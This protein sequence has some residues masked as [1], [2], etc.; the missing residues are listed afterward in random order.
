[1][2]CPYCG[3]EVTIRGIQWECGFCGDF[4]VLSKQQFLALHKANEEPDE[5]TITFSLT[6]DLDLSETWNEM[7]NTLQ[8]AIDEPS[9]P[10]VSKLGAVVIYEICHALAD[11]QRRL[12]DEKKEKLESFLKYTPD[13]GPVPSVSTLLTASSLPISQ[14]EVSPYQTIGKLTE[15]VCGTFWANLIEYLP[16]ENDLVLIDDLFLFLGQ[17]YLYFASDECDS[18]DYDRKNELRDAFEHHWYCHRY[19]FP[20]IDAAMGR[21]LSGDDSQLDD[22]C[23]DVLVT[24]FP[25]Y[26]Q[27]FSLDDMIDLEWSTLISDLLDYDRRLGLA[28]WQA[29]LDS[30]L[31]GFLEEQSSAQYILAQL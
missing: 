26:F 7:K 19:F 16:A 14:Q 12:P 2:R 29:L 6:F 25:E 30:S 27:Q 4:G 13:L 5:I 17:I 9:A 1:M 10:F 20:D 18:L 15:S 31:P 24:M 11:P 22:D 23:R 28:M 8:K 21:L 3:A